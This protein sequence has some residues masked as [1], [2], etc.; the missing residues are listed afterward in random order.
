MKFYMTFLGLFFFCLNLSA[1]YKKFTIGPKGDTLNAIT[2]DGL[3]VGK[4]VTE[5][6]ELRG[7]PAYTEE[8]R[9]NKKGEREGY[10]RKY[11]SLG[12]LLAVEHYKG[13]GKDGLQQYFSYLGGL[14]REEQWRGYNPDAPFDTIP[15]Y[16]TG[17]GEIVEYKLVRAEQYSVKQGEWRYYD[18][19]TGRIIRTEKWERNNLITPNN[20]TSNK[21]APS[22]R[23]AKAEKPQEILE[24]ERKN[25]G[26]KVLDGRTSY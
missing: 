19:G 21:Q 22:A 26:K 3:K 7:E 1:Q 4:W 24:W 12:D 9:Y 23:P 13:G 6:P 14:E 16:G 17:S 8:G 11:T 2:H 20:Q 15:V 25:K 10:W 5:I 18:P